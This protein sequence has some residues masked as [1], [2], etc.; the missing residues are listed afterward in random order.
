MVSTLLFSAAMPE[1]FAAPEG[2][3]DMVRPWPSGLG[4]LVRPEVDP[5]RILGFRVRRCASRG[6]S[7][8]SCGR[9]GLGLKERGCVAAST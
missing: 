5:S 8:M 4:A 1:A 9:A 3:P 6:A 2:V 7:C